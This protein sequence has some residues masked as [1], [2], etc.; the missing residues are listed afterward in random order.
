METTV[1]AFL[2][3]GFYLEQ[4]VKGQRAGVDAM[5]LAASVPIVGGRE[6]TVLDAGAGSG[7]VALSVASRFPAARVTA[8]ERQEEIAALAG[9]N[10][11]RNRFSSRVRVITGDL[12]RPLSELTKLG[13]EVESFD[14]VVANP[15]FYSV[16]ESRPCAT[17]QK[18]RAHRLGAG[19]LGEWLRFLT[20]MARPRGTISLIHRPESLP[21]ILSLA[22]GRFGGLI[23][24]PIRSK[25]NEAA[26]RVLVQG[27]KGSRAPLRLA[28][29]LALNG[30]DGAYSAEANAIL[31]QGAAWRL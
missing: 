11:E 15:P 4:P 26:I 17:E 31:R 22:Q 19:E 6:Q 2:D 16:D 5:L 13:L 21:D 18:S 29:G 24:A 9:L 20:A 3:G 10:V 27:V 7:P 30:D 14:H 8:I 12:T 1:D 23:I 28:P 25:R